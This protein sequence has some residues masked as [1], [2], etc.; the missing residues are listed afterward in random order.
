[1]SSLSLAVAKHESAGCFPLLLRP[2]GGVLR[3]RVGVRRPS[4]ATGH[5]TA[6]ARTAPYVGTGEGSSGLDQMRRSG[7][8][9]SST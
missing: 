3:Y 1:M 8:R 5:V 4:H 2:Q 7:R 9:P 6:S